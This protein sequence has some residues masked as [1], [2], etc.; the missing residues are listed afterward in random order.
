MCGIVGLLLR[1]DGLRPALGEMTLPM[2]HCMAERGPDSAGLAVW[3][4]PQGGSV[5]RYSLFSFDRGIDWTHLGATFEAETGTKGKIESV[6]NHAVLTAEMA[7]DAFTAWVERH[8]QRILLLSAGRAVDVYKDMG[9]PV[10]IAGRYKFGAIRGTH[11]IGH[12]RMA[13]ESAISPAHAH[14]YTAGEDFC[15]VHNGSLSNPYMTRRR[16]EAKGLR[17]Q[18]DNDTEAA[19]RLIEWRLREGDTLERAVGSAIEALDGFYTLLMA[20]P[21]TMVL[22]RDAFACKPGVVAETD[23][24]VAV[25]SEFRSL[26]ELPGIAGAKIYEPDPE[27]IY[28]WTLPSTAA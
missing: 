18:T 6:D 13:T 1:K 3:N 8:R 20:T 21:D 10:E 26:A 28:T 23:D 5:R 16:L 4:P 19:C 11:A 17:F 25:A 24:Y 9:N 2:F 12:T 15:L 27:V 7:P 14:P 22:V